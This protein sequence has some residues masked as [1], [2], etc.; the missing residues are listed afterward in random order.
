ML[1]YSVTKRGWLPCFHLGL[2]LEWVERERWGTVRHL[3]NLLM[4]KSSSLQSVTQLFRH[5]NFVV[6]NC[7][8]IYPTSEFYSYNQFSENYQ[9]TLLLY[10]D[11]FRPYL[12]SLVILWQRIFIGKRP[13]FPESGITVCVVELT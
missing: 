12:S 4:T 11:K 1:T 13:K 7:H 2:R 8:A 9:V 5:I 3:V 10:P 6:R